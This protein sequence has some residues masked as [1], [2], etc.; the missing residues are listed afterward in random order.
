MVGPKDE[1]QSE[2]QT[3]DDDQ[4]KTTSPRGRV[5]KTDFLKP[6]KGGR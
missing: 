4:E 2:A 6:V 5:K 3:Q 1:E